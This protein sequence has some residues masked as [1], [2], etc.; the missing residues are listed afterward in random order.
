[1]VNEKDHIS[2]SDASTQTNIIQL[3][4]ASSEGDDDGTEVLR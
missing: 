2:F 1:M 4:E 3:I